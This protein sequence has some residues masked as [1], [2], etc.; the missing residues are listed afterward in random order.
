MQEQSGLRQG[1][2]PA[3]IGLALAKL[4]ENESTV[5]NRGISAELVML[6]RRVPALLA[7]QETAVPTT[8]QQP[9]GVEAAT[10]DGLPQR[11]AV[12]DQVFNARINS[13]AEAYLAE[14]RA[15]AIMRRP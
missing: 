6:C 10:A 12:S 3:D 9:D 7:N 15:N 13:M 2:I 11:A 14:L 1:Q 5:I 8:A 4:D